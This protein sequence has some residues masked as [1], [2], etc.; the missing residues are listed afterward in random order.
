MRRTKPRRKPPEKLDAPNPDISFVSSEQMSGWDWAE[1]ISVIGLFTVAAL[2]ALFVLQGII[3]PVVTAWVMGAVLRPVVDWARTFGVPRSLAVI[4]TALA[5]LLI[6]L[7]LIGLL[8]TPFTYWISRTEELASLIREKLELLGEPLSIFDGIG[9]TLAGTSGTTAS[10]PAAGYD[11]TTIISAILSTLSPV[12]T[13]FMLFFFAMIFWMLYA[14]E[15]KTGI[16]SIFSSQRA[17]EIVQTVLDE[18]ESNVSHY[19]GTL[20]VVNLF[21]GVLAAG[22]AWIVGLP[23]PL[24]WAV[25]AGTLNFIPYLGPVVTMAT[26]FVVGI[27]ALPNPMDAV[28]APL[29]WLFVN[30]LE[31]SVITPMIVGRRHTLNPFLVFLSI[32]FWAW[33]WGPMGALLA[34]PLLIAVK[35]LG[36]HLSLDSSIKEILPRQSSP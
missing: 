15:I 32:A 11:T 14:N 2:Y 7:A 31:G 26:F 35:V 5:A 36:R 29:V 16:A 3:V 23:N 19:F 13:Q 28:I 30:T 21:L 9:Q 22:L 8:A 17:R 12:V 4:I 18:T 25:L 24:L 33:I 1:R 27:I 34:V 10:T 20:G 6:L